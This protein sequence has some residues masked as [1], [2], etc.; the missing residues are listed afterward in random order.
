[1]NA[2][3]V[4]VRE[5]VVASRRSATYWTRFAVAG[6]ALACFCL[7]LLFG[8]R[9]NTVA[10]QGKQIFVVLSVMTFT[11]CSLAG[12]FAT[13]DCLSSER[14][15]G[16]LGLLFLTDLRTLD[17]ILG[18]LAAH[19]LHAVFGLLAVVPVMN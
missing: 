7:M 18:K 16:T 14:R 15:N 8:S 19:S 2:L 10:M 12:V 4:V 17:V 11:Y 3:P 5:L 1:M 13:T 6:V 9:T